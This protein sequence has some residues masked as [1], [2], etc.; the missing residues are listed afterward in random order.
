MILLV[1]EMTTVMVAVTL[2]LI[3]IQKIVATSYILAKSILYFIVTQ[4]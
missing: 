3:Q 1:T 4:A 2:T